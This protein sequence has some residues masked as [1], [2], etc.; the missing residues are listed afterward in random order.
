MICAVCLALAG[1]VPALAQE[2]GWI[3]VRVADQSE[4]GVLVQTVEPN[5]PAARAG[6]RQNDII[7][8][9]DR[10]DVTG[11]IQLTRLV[12]E[13][14]VGRAVD[15][16]VK[17]DNRDQTLKITVEAAPD[18]SVT[19]R[20]PG[21]N[22]DSLRD[23]RDQLGRSMTDSRASVSGIRVTSMTPQL[24]EFFGAKADEGVLV[25][26]VDADSQG[27]RAGLRAGDVIV[28]VNGRTIAT[29]ADLVRELRASR[30]GNVLKI[31]RDK[32]EREI[33]L[34]TTRPSRA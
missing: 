28:A 8:R 20:L 12:H 13:T 24:R 30:T 14:P 3:G 21:L 4:S 7:T 23:L 9:F 22:M 33:R 11:V 17:R 34:D 16:T 19:G 31:L 29:P 5:S 18:R 1:A 27:S 2:A 10:Q 26:T 25:A 32:R 15:V 6:I